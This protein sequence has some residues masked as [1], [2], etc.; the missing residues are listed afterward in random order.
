MK[1]RIFSVFLFLFILQK[2]FSQSIGMKVNSEFSNE[3]LMNNGKGIGIY[4]NLNDFDDKLELLFSIDYIKANKFFVI[5]DITKLSYNGKSEKKGI[6]STLVYVINIK[7]KLKFKSGPSISYNDITNSKVYTPINIIEISNYK[8]LG[9]GLLANFQ[10]VE[11]FQLPLNL[12]VFIT[13]IHLLNLSIKTDPSNLQN[14]QNR[15]FSLINSQIGLSF[16]F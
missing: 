5:D 11:I 9:L 4:L 3:T 15:N 13:P 6:S 1:L 12:D 14:N 10:F 8:S 7:E 16:Q 2:A